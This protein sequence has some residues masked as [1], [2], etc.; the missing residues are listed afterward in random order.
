MCR[1]T[2]LKLTTTATEPTGKS[3]VPL[4]KDPSGTV[5][6]FAVTQIARCCSGGCK[7][8]PVEEVDWHR[9]EVCRYVATD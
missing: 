5:K 1:L 6:D 2:K 7:D 4:L 8:Q 9:W 3:L